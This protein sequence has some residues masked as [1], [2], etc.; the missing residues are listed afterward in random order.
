MRAN[1]RCPVLFSFL[2]ASTSLLAVSLIPAQAVDDGRCAQQAEPRRQPSA[3]E[4]SKKETVAST[5][6]RGLQY[7]EYEVRSAAEAMPEEHTA[8]VPPRTNS[9][10]KSRSS[11]Q[12]KCAHLRNK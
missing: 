8:T 6:L 7:Q 1:H 5:F 10:M 12:P 3:A 2:A 4:M 11:G 9:K